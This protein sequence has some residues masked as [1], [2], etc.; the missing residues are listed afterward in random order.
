MWQVS[1]EFMAAVR[2]A[3]TMTTTVD[4]LDN[5]VA[6]LGDLPVVGGSIVRDRKAAQYGRCS[7]Q[8]ED[9]DLLPTAADS[10]LGPAGFELVVKRGIAGEMVPLGIFPIQ[11]SDVDWADLTTGIEAVDRSQ[12]VADARLETDKHVAP[13]STAG[14]NALALITDIIPDVTFDITSVEDEASGRLIW[15][16]QSDRWQIVQDV[17]KA[18]G[19]EIFFNGIGA[20]VGR[21]E[22]DLR[23]A[24]PVWT[25]D[26]GDG[27]VLV[28]GSTSWSRRPSFNR[29]IVTGTNTEF[30]VTYRGVATDSAPSSPS[31]YSGRFGPKPYFFFSPHVT[32]NTGAVRSAKGILRSLQG[33]AMSLDFSAVPNPALEPGDVVVVK[34]EAVGLDTAV[35]VDSITLGLGPEDGMSCQV[36]ARQEDDVT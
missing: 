34:R 11:D 12:R 9:P 5:G 25:V 18:L 28:S 8:L 21:P 33:V 13:G 30:G 14:L 6:I 2:G 35:I 24:L 19:A 3:H 22:P 26:E 27:G 7:I 4:V 23:T 15:E 36:R 16:A 29:V 32:S 20:V 10:P 1:D 17:F 31:Y